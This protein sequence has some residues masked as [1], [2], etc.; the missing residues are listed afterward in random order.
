ML[1]KRV[2][3]KPYLVIEDLGKD[4][5]TVA[6]ESYEAEE[7]I[8]ALIREY[9]RLKEKENKGTLSGLLTTWLIDLSVDFQ[10]LGM[11]IGDRLLVGAT[12]K[13]LTGIANTNPGAFKEM[14]LR[15]F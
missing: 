3:P 8:K 1:I 5:Q 9:A 10:D 4:K 2:D 6:L 12:V 11:T 13:L 14:V 7:L 15:P